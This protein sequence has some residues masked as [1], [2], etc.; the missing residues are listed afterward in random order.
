[1]GSHIST[2]FELIPPAKMVYSTVLLSTLLVVYS[3]TA[4]EC[5]RTYR[6]PTGRLTSP[7]FP[8]NYPRNQACS[9]VIRSTKGAK[10]K[11]QF[12]KFKVERTSPCSAD[13]LEIRNGA[14][15]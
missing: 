12:K 2:V 4:E 1:M 7:N 9:A 14:K 15:S 8:R 5:G 6:E 13:Y 10:I 3:T 11:L